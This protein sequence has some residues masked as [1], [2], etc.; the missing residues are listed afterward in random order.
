VIGVRVLLLPVA[1]VG[2]TPGAGAGGRP[3]AVAVLTTTPASTSA[4]VSRYRRGPQVIEA[5]TA[6]VLPGQGTAP[7]SSGSFNVM[8]LSATLPALVSTKV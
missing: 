7:P 2:A 3:R 4:W 6:S 5:P 8:P 1:A